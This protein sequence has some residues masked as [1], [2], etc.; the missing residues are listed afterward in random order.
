MGALDPHV[1]KQN[2]QSV[3]GSNGEVICATGDTGEHIQSAA[4]LSLDLWP[5]LATSEDYFSTVRLSMIYQSS[6]L[7][8]VKVIVRL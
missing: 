8:S 1:H 7:Y 5:S 3:P 2:E 4:E 6:G